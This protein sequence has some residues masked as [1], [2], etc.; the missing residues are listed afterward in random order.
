M[1]EGG[2]ALKN[3][4]A[5]DIQFPRWE[6][7]E[8]LAREDLFPGKWGEEFHNGRQDRENGWRERVPG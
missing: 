2:E 7:E 5:V 3:G 6:E 4:A 1:G 8:D